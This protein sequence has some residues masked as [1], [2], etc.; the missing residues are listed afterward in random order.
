[1]A[2]FNI[3]REETGRQI[4]GRRKALY[5]TREKLAEALSVETGRSTTSVSV[6]KWETGRCEITEEYARAL[7]EIFGCRVCE[8]VVAYLSFYDDER[9]Q[10][11]HFEIYLV[12]T[13]RKSICSL[14]ML[15]F[16]L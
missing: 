10:L 2:F 16:T 15:F 3:N 13:S 11:G 9:D 5:L 14:Q 12:I 1:M 7:A 8:L 4:L 6:W